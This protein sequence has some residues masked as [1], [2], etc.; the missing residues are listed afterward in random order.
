MIGNQDHQSG[1]V[2]FLLVL[3]VLCPSMGFPGEKQRP[4]ENSSAAVSTARTIIYYNDKTITVPHKI[5]RV[6][7][8]WPAQNSVIAMLG[9]GDKIVA[10]YDMIKASPIFAK[11]VPGIRNAVVSFTSSGEL[12]IE[13]L[14]Q[15]KPDVVFGIEAGTTSGQFRRLEDMGIPVAYLKGNSLPNLV[16]R[17]VITGQILGDDA[18]RRALHYVNY[19]AEN[20]RR[21]GRRVAKIPPTQRI[22]VYHSIGNPLMTHGSPSLVQDWMA[23]AGVI[24]I[25]RDWNL[26]NPRTSGRANTNLEQII[27]G[28][29]AAIVCMYAADAQTIKTDARWSAIRA[30][31][32]GKVYVNPKGMFWWCRETTEEALQFLW[33]AKTVYPEYFKDIDMAEETKHFYKTFYGFD[34]SDEDVQLFLYP[35]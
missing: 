29:P 35:K 7:S 27:A 32:D 33:L 13:S 9:Y 21:V 20:V 5:T 1:I 34:L 2:F 26:I 19:Y 11:F 10:T 8:G 22:K 4:V 25:A 6:A 17:A 30:V 16:D 31:R 28:N 14:V 3:I 23:V 15:A 12:N 24:N 18:H